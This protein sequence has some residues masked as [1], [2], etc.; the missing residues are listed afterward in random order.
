M[1]PD[2]INQAADLLVTARHESRP[3]LLPEIC[4]PQDEETA[5]AIQQ[6]VTYRLALPLVG[7][8]V[9]AA[10]KTVADAEGADRAVSGRLFAPYVHHSPAKLNKALFTSFRNCEVEFVYRLGQALPT[11][12]GPYTKSEVTET[13]E[14]VFPA[15]EIGDS[16]LTDRSTAG[17]LTICADNAGGT[18]LVLGNEI[19]TWQHVDL[20]SHRATLQINHQEVAH[21]YGRDVM[22]DPINSL[23]WLVNQQIAWG[24]AIPAGSLVATGSCTGINIAQPGDAVV[25]N[26]G[27]LGEVQIKFE[28]GDR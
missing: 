2:Q 20:S 5:Y 26:F 15:I 9:G 22:G 8:K 10:S 23:V 24:H 4:R 19:T 11:R 18:Q 28:A 12:T 25:A 21:G 1:S 17:M 16:R 13:V 6:A 27:T 3:V 14:A 7:W